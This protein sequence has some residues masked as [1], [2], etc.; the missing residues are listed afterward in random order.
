MFN[1]ARFMSRSSNRSPRRVRESV[2][3]MQVES[4][5]VRQIPATLVSPTTLTYQD[6]DGDNVT[7][8]FSQPVL[9]AGNVNAVF[10]F[11]TGAGAVN[12]NNNTKQMLLD[13]D[14]AGQLPAVLT[15]ITTTATK[16]AVNGG[17]GFATLGRL[18][19]NFSNAPLGTVTIDGDLGQIFAGATNSLIVQSLGRFGVGTGATDLVSEINTKLGSLMVKGDIKE[20]RVIVYGDLGAVTING[21]LIGGVVSSTG[22]IQATKISGAVLIKGDIVGGGGVSSGSV[23]SGTTTGNVTVKGSIIGGL[24]TASGRLSAVSGMGAVN[25]MGNLSGGA[26]IESGNIRINN[27][28]IASLTIGGSV[29]G[30]EG[31]LS[32]VIIA[33]AGGSIGNVTITGDVAGNLL[34]SG[35]GNAS[36]MS[37]GTLGNVTIGGSLIGGLAAGSGK[38]ESVGGMGLLKITGNVVGSGGNNSASISSQSKIAGLTVGGSIQGGAGDDSARIEAA[39]DL[40]PVSVTGD[41]KGGSGSNSAIIVSSEKMG[42]V[43]IGGSVIGGSG[44]SGGRI[45]SS[46]EMGAVKVTGSVVGGGGDGT[47]SISSPKKIAGVT[48][49]GSIIGGGSGAGSVESLGE[50]TTV[51]ILGDIVGGSASGTEFMKNS[52]FLGAGRIISLTLGGSLIAGVD[53]TSATYAHNG[54]IRVSD[55]LGTVLIKGSVVGNNTN[56]AV[57]S[58]R[59][60]QTTAAGAADVAIGSL[61]VNG[62]V[63][64]ALIQAGVDINGNAKNADAQIT[65]V[66][67]LGDWIAS[68]LV[69]GIVAGADAKFGTAD[70]A[71]MSGG[72][73]KDDAV[74]KS[75]IGAIA[76][77]GQALGTFGGSDGFAFTAQ[78]IAILRIGG[79]AQITTA[80]IDDFFIG[81]TSDLKLREIA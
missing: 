64:N 78:E 25:V 66:N 49:G 54:A 23:I 79:V 74:S 19:T 52:G 71:K 46:K 24:G 77:T 50:I 38:V 36:I 7:V 67:V 31:I 22:N 39:S 53:N 63:E 28:S 33:A 12:G 34:N 15:N 80:N 5:E 56:V 73:V 69:A 72:A 13:I 10:N 45:K 32:G 27:G 59:G 58:A 3:P 16:S 41:V 76:I 55:D 43:T 61:T 11:S 14:L 40:G 44:S 70:D 51:S 17:D 26:G 18:S 60:K 9:N 1:F 42:A 29:R 2:Q 30:G 35:M 65:T 8:K 81:I 21:S 37:G 20:A 57:I 75:K 47:A 48:I 4:L 6:L 62:R 68:S